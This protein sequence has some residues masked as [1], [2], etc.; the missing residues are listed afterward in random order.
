VRGSHAGGEMLSNLKWE[1]LAGTGP[2][3]R[4]NRGCRYHA[5][6][7]TAPSGRRSR[8]WSWANRL[9]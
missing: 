9:W 2:G 7:P 4:S 1:V 8:R 3:E 5:T 6:A